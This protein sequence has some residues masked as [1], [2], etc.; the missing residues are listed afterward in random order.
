L[1]KEKQ[2]RREREK[3]RQRQELLDTALQLFSQK[4]YH[5]VSMHE[6]AEKAEFAIGTL[7]KFFKNKEDLYRS[8]VL[9][10]AD[11]FDVKLTEAISGPDNEMEKI[12]RFIR[13]KGEIFTRR[14]QM[15]QLYFAETRGI[16]QNMLASMDNEIRTRHQ[17]GI[18]K[19][20]EI[21]ESGIENGF[22]RPVAAP[23]YL[24]IA[25]DN[26]ISSFL[27]LWIE[28]P[29]SHPLPQGIETIKAIFFKQILNSGEDVESC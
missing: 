6:I 26:L 23:F 12:C 1:Q 14:K 17:R 16:S 3:L 13:V 9:E 15:I 25:L 24:A 21:F 28:D 4:G 18:E 20:A 29:E 11:E 2:S 22:F 8:M 27:F 19:L 10:Q 5:N 7:Y